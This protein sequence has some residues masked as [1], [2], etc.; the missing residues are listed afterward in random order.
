MVNE[1]IYSVQIL[2]DFCEEMVTLLLSLLLPVYFKI[3][4]V[5]K[6]ITRSMVSDKLV[7]IH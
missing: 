4:K 5:G 2:T 7:Y 1:K 3:W 6:I